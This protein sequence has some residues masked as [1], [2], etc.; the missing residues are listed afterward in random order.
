VRNFMPE[1]IYKS[2][3]EI[4]A[5]LEKLFAE[6]TKEAEEEVEEPTE[7]EGETSDEPT[8]QE[9]N[10]D[11]PEPKDADTTDDEPEVAE[12]KPATKPIVAE[13][14][15]ESKQ[16][17]AFKQLREEAATS[18]KQLQEYEDKMKDLNALAQ[19]QGFNTYD[20]FV[21]AWKDRQLE[22]QAKKQNTDPR[23]L[24]ELNETKSRL[25]Q[26][27][28][29]KIEADKQVKLNK[30]NTTI[31][32]FAIRYGLNDENVKNIIN[33][34]GEDNLTLESLLITPSETLDKMLTGYAQ[35]IIIERKVQEKLAALEKSGTTPAPEKHKNTVSNKKPDPFSKEALNDEMDAF[36]KENYPWLK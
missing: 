30:I 10:D 27:E 5:D 31:D 14:Q 6:A 11:K 18:K 21:K 24:K 28:K 29:E 13:P 4:D 26:I 20:D 16:D 32:K 1:K 34:M 9:T 8:V 23:V 3:A 25:T 12:T 22:D 7:A 15:K 2:V 35:D 17:Y 19:A 33:K 36:K